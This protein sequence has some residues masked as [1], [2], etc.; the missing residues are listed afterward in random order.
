MSYKLLSTR[1]GH[2][3][4]EI[5]WV[6]RTIENELAAF[7]GRT[8]VKAFDK[9]L[10]SP[11]TKVLEAGCGLGAW[12]EWFRRRGNSVVGLEYFEGV[13]NRAKVN[14]PDIPV[15]LGDITDIKYDDN[16]FDAYVSLGVL[17]HF[18][19]GPEKA[20]AEAIRILKSGGLVFITVPLLTPLR[21]YIAH[22]IRNLYF[23]KQ[24]LIG[25]PSYFWEYRYTREELRGYIEK[26]GF[27][28]IEEGVDDFEKD[29]KYRHIGLW[30]DWFFLRQQ[31]E[32]MWGLNLAG[33]I[34]LSLFKAL[35]SSWYC[36]GWLVVARIEK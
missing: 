2:A 28:I 12:C 21:K 8:L 1:T 36:S 19:H 11:K 13:V 5:Q 9:Y 35:P 23:L 17:E 27:N 18:E 4:D 29:I 34:I 33:R 15:E 7:E 26:A 14:Q 10:T 30:A 20:L 16:S 31:S 6:G 32:D 22:P 25:K 3:H 24:K